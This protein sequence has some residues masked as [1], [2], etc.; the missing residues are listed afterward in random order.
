MPDEDAWPVLDVVVEGNAD[1]VCKDEPDDDDETLLEIVTEVEADAKANADAV[2]LTDCVH[3]VVAVAV[4]EID[5]DA[6]GEDV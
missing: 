2:T 1:S 6:D 5:G 4:P 3:E